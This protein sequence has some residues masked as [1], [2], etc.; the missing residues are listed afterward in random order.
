[1]DAECPTVQRVSI[2]IMDAGLTA[3]NQQ[4]ILELHQR[5]GNIRDNH[6][7]NMK[8]SQNR[9]TPSSHP[10]WKRIFHYRLSISGYPHFG[11]H[12]YIM[13]LLPYVPPGLC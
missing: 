11:K 7:D 12:P 6:M 9:G 10:F 8:V 3:A 13:I 5:Y 1:M 4:M 2:K